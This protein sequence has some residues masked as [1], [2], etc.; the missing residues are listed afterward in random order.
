MKI[1]HILEEVDPKLAVRLLAGEG[2]LSNPVTSV[3]AIDHLIS[4]AFIDR[5]EL[6]ILISSSFSSPNTL[7]E[8]IKASYEAGASGILYNV[9][10]KGHLPSQACQD[11]CREKQFPL[12]I[13]PWNQSAGRVNFQIVEAIVRHNRN[14][15]SKKYWEKA[16]GGENLDEELYGYPQGI[17]EVKNVQVGRITFAQSDQWKRSLIRIEDFVASASK[18]RIYFFHKEEENALVFVFLDLPPGKV[19]RFMD[20]CQGYCKEQKISARLSLSSDRK[21][22]HALKKCDQ[23]A[24]YAQR[25]IPE[26]QSVS[27]LSDQELAFFDLLY[28]IP[29]EKKKAYVQKTL[30]AIEEY[31]RI[32]GADLTTFLISW[33]N[34]NCNAQDT[35]AA[36]YVHVNTVNYRLKKISELLGTD[37][38]DT[39]KIVQ[40]FVALSLALLLNEKDSEPRP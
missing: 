24:L 38:L 35:A 36:E 12:L 4:S 1:K 40:L 14:D 25:L 5:G 37:D 7:L 6:V 17:S 20:E 26:S 34:H 13:F 18:R 11:F 32:K 30:S 33:L 10:E 31:D 22:V 21:G 39:R 9:D 8:I 28:E 16:L 3:H 29:E 19:F 27:M 15:A 23:E 2:G